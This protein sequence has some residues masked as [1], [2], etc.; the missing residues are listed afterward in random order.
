MTTDAREPLTEARVIAITIDGTTVPL[1]QPASDPIPLAAFTGHTLTDRSRVFLT[2]LYGGR[3]YA[4]RV[5][6][7]L[8]S[9]VAMQP[10]VFLFASLTVD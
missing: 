5:D 8:D 6:L 1:D 3:S 2:V 9:V 4:V 7:D 10:D